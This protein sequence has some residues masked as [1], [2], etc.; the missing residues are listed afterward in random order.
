MLELGPSAGGEANGGTE[1]ADLAGPQASSPTGLPPKAITT[2]YGFPTTGGA[3]E[4]IALIDAYDDPTIA[5]NLNTFSSQYGLPSCTA[6]NGCFAKV[7]QTGG[8]SYPK[9]T[10][11]WSLEISLD[12]E[13]AHALA[14]KA[15]IILV[16]ANSNGFT[17][18]FKA[19][20]YAT[21]HA[22]YVSM[23]WGGTE[24]LGEKN[25]DSDFT[26][27]PSVS[28]FASSGDKAKDVLYPAASPDVISVGGTTLTVT[29]TTY[30]WKGESAWST[31]GGGCSADEKATGAQKA[32]PTYDQSGVPCAG[33][34]AI[35]DVALDGNPDTGVSV[36]DSRTLSTGLVNWMTVGG[37]SA[38]TVMW[39]ARSAVAGVHVNST[40]IYGDN[41]P[42]Y[43]VTTGSNGEPC[44]K[45]YNLC[46]GLGSWSQASGTVNA[47]LTIAPS[48]QT[49][50]AGQPSTAM[51]LDVSAPAP[52]G[53]L[54][55]SLST[56]SSTGGFSSTTTG[57]FAHTLV[58]SV[59]TGATSSG[60][61]YY[62]DTKAGSPVLTAA[63]PNWVP[64][65]QPET[66]NPGPVS[67]ITVSPASV[68]LAEGA[69]R[70]FVATGF[71]RFTNPVVAGFDPAW[72]TTVSGGS[73]SSATAA[74]TTFTAGFSAESGAVTAT[75]AGVQSTASVVVNAL[76]Q[77]AS[78][79]NNATWMNVFY[80]NTSG[81]LMNAWWQ[82]TS[83]WHDQEL[84]T[85]M[86]G[87]PAAIVNSPTWMDVFYDSTAG[88]LMN[89]W[90]QSTSGWHDQVLATGMVGNPTAVMRSRHRW[91]SSTRARA[92]T[93]C[94][95]HGCPPAVGRCRRWSAA[96]PGLPPRWP[97]APPGWTS[98]TRAPQ[99]VW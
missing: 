85:G 63:T 17:D 79:A 16:E 14:P 47:S 8:T 31:A 75:Q 4:T 41:I 99:A 37:T 50:T 15:H 54:S 59:P 76:S 56:S 24:F 68:S 74:S 33:A 70:T 77:P 84:A 25:L 35:P 38:S 71:D 93:S 80:D 26:A 30:A 58:I 66:V 34:R 29:K 43:N 96:S 49:L 94:A 55:I 89:A 27:S 19:I 32:Y 21:Q 18:L 67:R 10:S 78:V 69:N 98:S 53:G 72:T 97:T 61:F 51:A 6:T 92:A 12:V 45:G 91:T 39:A 23:S 11:G 57:P 42:F 9:A 46:T 73:L 1:N 36:Y 52:A 90:W 86:T 44:E 88:D 22:Q 2:A 60:S 62:E 81:D 20:T 13:W 48:A 65:T 64:V 83:G 87:S 7:N 95:P 5:S 82:S 28:F 40:Y 3:G